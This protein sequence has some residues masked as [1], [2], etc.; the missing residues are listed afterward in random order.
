MNSHSFKIIIV[1]ILSIV[2]T[3]ALAACD[4]GGNGNGNHVGNG[5][6]GLD[7]EFD[8]TYTEMDDYFVFDY[9]S[10]WVIVSENEVTGPEPEP[11]AQSN[12]EKFIIVE[13]ADADGDI[14]EDEEVKHMLVTNYFI[15]S[16]IEYREDKDEFYEELEDIEEDELIEEVDIAEETEFQDRPAY[17]LKAR[18]EYPELPNDIIQHAI[19]VYENSHQQPILYMAKEGEYSENIAYTFFDSYE[20]MTD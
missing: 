11:E 16:D 7:I 15:D 9:P 3:G 6:D 13:V 10:E 18:M 1:L 17:E 19:L 4:I 14:F 2:L 12:T 8:A 20:Y 5:N